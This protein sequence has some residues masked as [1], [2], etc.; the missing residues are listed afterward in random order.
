M[1]ASENK[2]LREEVERWLL[3]WFASRSKMRASETHSLDIDYFAAGWLT[4]MEVVEFVTD[5]EAQFGMTFTD[6]DL[7]D[8]RFATIAG[9]SELIVER[10]MQA[11][12][13]VARSA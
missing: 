10:T 2:I 6:S 1:T 7:Q 13:N 11:S 8:A 5:I 3:N 9:L 12:E 4:S